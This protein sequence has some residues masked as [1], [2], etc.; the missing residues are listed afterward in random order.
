MP[1]T[2][3]FQRCRVPWASSG[4]EQAVRTSRDTQGTGRAARRPQPGLT[5]HL[6]PHRMRSTTCSA[7]STLASGSPTPSPA[8]PRR[9]RRQAP[10][11]PC[12]KPAPSQATRRMS[13]RD[14]PRLPPACPQAPVCPFSENKNR[15][16]SP[17][18]STFAAPARPGSG[19]ELPP[20]HCP[21]L[22][23]HPSLC[24]ESRG[25][26]A[27][28]PPPTPHPSALCQRPEGPGRGGGR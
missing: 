8:R 3:H 17:A 4:L 5:H 21:H 6:S 9:G 23:A 27:C 1:I 22:S 26:T 7:A 15:C 10:G 28:R 2:G 12:W 20:S 16:L 13:A 18:P 24:F 19:R 11:T 25:F 14:S